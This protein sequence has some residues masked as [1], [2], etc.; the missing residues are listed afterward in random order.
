MAS[1]RS[2]RKRVAEAILVTNAMTGQTLARIGNLSVDGMMLISSQPIP[3][4]RLYQVHFHLR[5]GEQRG[6][7][8]EVGIQCQW[9]ETARTPNTYWAGCKIIDIAPD[10]QTLLNA[11]VERAAEAA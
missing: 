11:W 4:E 1:R 10:E 6:H 5:D 9:T 8:L 3:E 7:R 2:V